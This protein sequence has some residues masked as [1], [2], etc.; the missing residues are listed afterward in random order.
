VGADDGEARYVLGVSPASNTVTV[1]PR[2]ALEVTSLTGTGVS[3]CGPAPAAGFRGSVQVRAHGSPVACA[4][5][6]VDPLV[7]DLDSPLVAVAPGQTL[8][9]YDGTRVVGAA[10]LS[11]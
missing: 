3:W 7:V 4:V 6:S 1:G 2:S 8:A 5:R 9:L 10:T 11:P